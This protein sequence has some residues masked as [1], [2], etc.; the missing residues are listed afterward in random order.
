MNNQAPNIQEC[1]NSPV[2][3]KASLPNETDKR[4]GGMPKAV[5]NSS[6]M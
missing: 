4:A 1:T 3:I 2:I 6:D 5:E